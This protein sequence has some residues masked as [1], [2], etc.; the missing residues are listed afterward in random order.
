MCPHTMQVALGIVYIG[1]TAGLTKTMTTI[2]IVNDHKWPME[3]MGGDN[4]C[5]VGAN[6]LSHQREKGHES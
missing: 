3:E 1:G 5:S 2:Y 4:G 6:N